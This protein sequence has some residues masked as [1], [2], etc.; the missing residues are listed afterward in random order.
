MNSLFNYDEIENLFRFSDK[1]LE[2]K[3]N[4]DIYEK[5][6]EDCVGQINFLYLC[7]KQSACDDEDYLIMEVLQQAIFSL[8]ILLRE[9][10]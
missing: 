5:V 4:K 10:K 1:N 6:V 7:Y 8:E 9:N 3:I 2:H